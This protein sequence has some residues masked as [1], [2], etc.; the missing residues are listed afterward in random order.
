MG[1]RLKLSDLADGDGLG[2][3]DTGEFAC[4]YRS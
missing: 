3:L 1:Q 4:I 2:E